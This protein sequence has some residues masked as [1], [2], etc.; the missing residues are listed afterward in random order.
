MDKEKPYTLFVQVWTNDK[1]MRA[2]GD[3]DSLEEVI[4]EV[5]TGLR[6]TF[7]ENGRTS[8]TIEVMYNGEE[9]QH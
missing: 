2:A 5:S 9:T 8:V 3:A 1:G 7:K 6:K 4:R